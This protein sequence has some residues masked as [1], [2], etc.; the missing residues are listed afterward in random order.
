MIV[1][2]GATGQLGRLIVA[3]LLR[4]GTP[5][6]SIVAAVRQPARAAD[7]AAQGVQ[8]READ[9]ERP[10]TLDQAFA[11][12]RRVLLVSSSEIGRRV[13]QHQAVIDAARRQKVEQ[14]AYTSLLQAT[15][16]PLTQV[17]ADHADTEAALRQSGLRHTVL[18]NGWYHENYIE[19]LRAGLSRGVFIGASGSGR[20]SS[21][22]RADYAEAAA[23]VLTTPVAQTQVHELAGDES[24]TLHDLAGIAAAVTGRPLSYQDMTPDAFEQA[25]VGAG[26][27][28]PFAA[29]L[30][31]AEL[32]ASRGGLH[33]TSRSLSRLIGRPTTP[34]RQVL[35]DALGNTR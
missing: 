16:S 24:Y 20:I 35:A 17:A 28:A 7:L 21:A 4:R 19:S 23:V 18:R 9:Y 14:L 22:A 34:V 12:A 29:V 27:P 31:N 2:T 8:V 6:A 26:V 25:L 13:P 15:T 30:A 32:G 10:A 1:V 5:A 3:A 11:G 33:D